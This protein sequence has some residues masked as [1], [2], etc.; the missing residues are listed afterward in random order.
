MLADDS[1]VSHIVN[2]DI[3]LCA[4]KRNKDL[5]CINK[6]A[7]QRLVS[8]NAMKTIFMLFTIKRPRPIPHN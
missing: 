2:K 1:S 8:I 3:S 7:V 6:W 4:A 5:D